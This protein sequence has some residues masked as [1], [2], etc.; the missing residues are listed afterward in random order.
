M[1]LFRYLKK[2]LVLLPDRYDK[3]IPPIA[4][5]EGVDLVTEGVITLNRVIEY[6]N[7]Y[8]NTNSKYIDWFYSQDGASLIAQYLFEKA[9]DI[10]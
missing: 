6:A 7:N 5:I 3:D 8:L 9:T 4:L 1:H 10:N 2:N